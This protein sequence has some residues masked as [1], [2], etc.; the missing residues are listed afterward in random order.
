V[1]RINSKMRSELKAPALASLALAFASFGDAFLYPFLP[2]NN[3][4]VGVP[5]V[6]VGVLLSINRFVRIFSNGFM[7]HL[8]AKYG[9]RVLMIAAAI[10]AIIST[11]G[12]AFSH[13]I[14]FWLFF[15]VCWGLSFSAMRIGSIGYSLI[16]ANQGLALGIGRSLQEVGPM[17]A[18]FL[19]PFL[20]QHFNPDSIFILLAVFSLPAIYFAWN[21]PR[22]ED[23]TPPLKGRKFLHFPSALN[24]ITLLSAILIDGILIVVLGILFIRFGEN[25]SLLTATALAAFYLGYR[26]VCLVVF[27]PAGGWIADKFGIDRVFNISIAFVIAGLLVLLSGWTAAGVV[28]VFTFYSVNAAV[29]P[30]SASKNQSH[31]LAAVAENATWRDIGAAVGTLIGGFMI[32]SDY[33]TDV[34]LVVTL[35]MIILLMIH[36]RSTQGSFKFFLPWK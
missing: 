15:R 19:A 3:G 2:V 31:S 34:L 4:A 32:T 21:L 35:T 12:Y 22:Y 27:S 13:S 16:P 11:M 14:F 30:G 23:R 1:L 18:L 6:W 8:F 26:R 10:T 9:L 24:L 29:T 36:L 25:V 5:V 20:L 33:L 7:V 28:I 17:L